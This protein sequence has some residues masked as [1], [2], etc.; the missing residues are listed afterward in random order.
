MS[1][2]LEAQSE[3]RERN[4]RNA[5][6]K[7]LDHGLA[8]GLESQG[9]HLLGISIKYSAFDCLMTL[10]ADIDG[11]R[12]ICFIGSD[13]IINCFLKADADAHRYELQWTPDK[14]HQ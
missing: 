5:L 10:R 8:G 6:I 11:T 3:E 14:Y 1:R 4:K 12:H 9:V 13:T 7:A 2:Q